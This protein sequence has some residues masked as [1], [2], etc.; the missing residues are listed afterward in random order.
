MKESAP[1][2]GGELKNSG[3]PGV[4]S[5]LVSRMRESAPAHNNIVGPASAEPAFGPSVIASIGSSTKPATGPA[6]GPGVGP[7]FEPSFGPAVVSSTGPATRPAIGPAIGPAAK[8]PQNA[9]GTNQNKITDT[10]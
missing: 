9:N 10:I 5:D 2:Y 3:L 4:V 6:V 8:S 7:A 1:A